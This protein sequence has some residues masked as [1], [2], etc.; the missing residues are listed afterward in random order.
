MYFSVFDHGGPGGPELSSVPW[1]LLRTIAVIELFLG[2]KW[3]EPP[4]EKPLP[5]SLFVHELLAI[6]G[7]LGEHSPAALSARILALPPFARSSITED[8]AALILKHFRRCGYIDK[9]SE[10]GFILGIEGEKIVNRH[11]F[12]SVFP[13]EETFKVVFEGREMGTVNFA[14]SPGTSI[15]VAGK[16]WYVE[17]VDGARR[18]IRVTESEKIRQDSSRLWSGGGGHIHARIAETVRDIL[19]TRTGYGYLSPAAAAALEQGRR[20][21]REAGILEKPVAAAP[22]KAGD[23]F[24][25][26]YI[27]PWLGSSG[28]RTIDAFFKNPSVQKK[29]ALVSCEWEGDFYF[30]VETKFDTET[31]SAVLSKEAGTFLEAPGTAL[32][33]A[34]PPFSGKYDYLLPNELLAKQYAA[35]M[36]DT[37]AVLTCFLS[38]SG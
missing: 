21:A 27:T 30:S 12:Y 37:A 32:T 33:P 35:N 4:E 3:I 36:L 15:M 14:P 1:D 18:E 38:T 29:L 17:N 8:D 20:R 5:Y 24:T 26:S 6:L 31:F 7:S 25:R 2:E 10:G 28:M 9:T 22:R 34:T 13:G 19:S 23:F 11:S 16:A